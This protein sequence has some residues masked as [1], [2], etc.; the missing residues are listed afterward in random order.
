MTQDQIKLQAI[1][2]KTVHRA[3]MVYCAQH[4]I[5]LGKLITDAL[6]VKLEKRYNKG[7]TVTASYSY[8]KAMD[9]TTGVF[10]GESVGATTGSGVVP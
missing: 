6:Q 9:Y 10:N 4:A 5:T 2:P 3:A 1:V 7:F 8:S